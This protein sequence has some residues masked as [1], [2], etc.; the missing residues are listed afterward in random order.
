MKKHVLSSIIWCLTLTLSAQN[1]AYNIGFLFDEINEEGRTLLDL[2]KKEI[3]A[4]VGEDAVILFD[5]KNQLI[6]N[7]DVEKAK[8]N[9]DRLKKNCDII[10]SFG[11][12]DNLIIK[13]S[14]NYPKPV[15][16][17]GGLSNEVTGIVGD[18]ETSGIDN[19]TYITSANSF[20]EDIKSFRKLVDFKTIGIVVEKPL[21]ELIDFNAIFTNSL[22]GRGIDFKI[23]PYTIPDDIIDNLDGMDALLLASGFSLK[24]SEVQKLAQE[25]IA[26]KIPSFSSLRRTDVTNGILATNQPE[27]SFDKFFRRIALS[28]ESYING[29]NFSDLPVLLDF[30]KEITLNFNTAQAIGIPLRY[31]LIGQTDFVGDVNYN[32]SAEKVYD[33]PMLIED[34]LNGNLHLQSGQ[35]DVELSDQNVSSAKSNYLPLLT[36]NVSS[37]YVDPKLAEVSS[38][39]NPEFRT[40][41]N[42]TL[43][44][45]VFSESASANISISKSLAKAERENFNIRQLDAIFDAANAYFNTLISKANLAIQMRNLNLTKKN[46]QIAEENY[47]AGHSSKTD[48]LRFRSQEAQNTQMLVE[49]INR[50]SSGFLAINQ[51][52]NNAT[53]FQIDVKEATLNEELFEEYNY[54]QFIEILDSPVQREPFIGFL[55]QEALH[56]APELKQLGYNLDVAERQI[57]LF[58]KGRYLPTISLQGQYNYRFSESGAGSKF[59]RGFLPPPDGSYDV[60]FNL[61]LPIFNQTN[62]LVKLQTARTRYDQLEIN[63]SDLE[64]NIAAN[65]RNS[66]L[67][68]INQVSNIELSKVSEVSAMEALD[69]TQTAYSTGSVNI[70]QLLDAQN[71]Y[72]N[73]QI[74]KANATYKYLLSAL[75][76]ERFLGF[77]ILLNTEEENARFNQRFLEFLNKN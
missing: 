7:Y 46:L 28:V 22:E 69:L 25:L 68:L 57:S 55:I 66:V 19:L 43:Q 76:L 45:V 15:I 36:T 64:L 47:E 9:Y 71:N 2:L 58:D 16:T 5:T 34:V 32:P 26:K 1:N 39:Q 41:G 13:K 30:K 11:A 27:D 10:I 33:L 61:T 40:S 35:K 21:T 74:A 18:N 44:Q 72:L 24:E 29:T 51:L 23:I 8:T 48:V 77:F 4:V 73:A 49:A 37:S 54:D 14:T 52:T 38:G 62:N 53:D 70:V 20:S 56:N 65:I 50:L 67:N 59:P 63:R 12:F 3:K 31:S 17:I 42:V 60:R 75:E 6:S